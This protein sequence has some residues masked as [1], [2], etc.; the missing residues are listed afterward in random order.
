[1]SDKPENS[2]DSEELAGTM[3]ARRE[4]VIEAGDVR[5]E[6]SERQDDAPGAVRVSA[7]EKATEAP[8]GVRVSLPDESREAPSAVRVS[9]SEKS[10]DAPGAVNVVVN[11]EPVPQS[12]DDPQPEPLGFV[13]VNRWGVWA[14]WR[15]TAI[16]AAAVAVAAV[17]LLVANSAGSSAGGSV[18]AIA[19][20]YVVD[21]E[22]RLNEIVAG[23]VAIRLPEAERTQAERD[24]EDSIIWTYRPPVHLVDNLYEVSAVATAETARVRGVVPIGLIV[25]AD[26]GDVARAYVQAV[27]TGVEIGPPDPVLDEN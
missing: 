9:T 12:R 20:R 4:D 27:G 15:L 3:L 17:V 2:E 1:M 22:K 19:H 21:N 13:A 7:S 10:G 14:S 18:D 26:S 24:I 16:V 6:K 25:R 23:I 8:G 5:V 11:V